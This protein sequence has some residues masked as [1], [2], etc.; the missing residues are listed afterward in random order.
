MTDRS[1]PRNSLILALIVAVVIWPSFLLLALDGYGLHGWLRECRVWR[2]PASLGVLAVLSCASASVLIC[3]L[4]NVRCAVRLGNSIRRLPLLDQAK[5]AALRNSLPDLERIAL[6][7]YPCDAPQ[8]F[9]AG[10]RKPVIVLSSWLLE[11][12][13]EQE[14]AATV[15]HELAHIRRRDTLLMFWV[16]SLCPG[17]FGLPLLRRQIRHLAVLIENRADTMSANMTGGSLALA[18]ALTKVG[19]HLASPRSA[20]VPSLTGNDSP[21]VLR[22]RVMLLLEE[23]RPIRGLTLGLGLLLAGFLTGTSY[24]ALY[25]YEL[26]PCTGLHCDVKTMTQP[27]HPG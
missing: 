3:L 25:A 1:C 16:H 27:Q 13:D 26:P 9:T 24:L 21:S 18:S 17:G 14:I 19:K 10:W 4:I 5:T 20:P 11:N 22:Q 2:E 15:A 12:L 7:V 8:A 6:H 23:R